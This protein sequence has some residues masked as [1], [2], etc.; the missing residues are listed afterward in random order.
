MKN[1]KKDIKN[2]IDFYKKAEKLKT[3]TRHSWTSNPSRQESVAEHSWMLCLL[4]ILL[5]DKLDGKVNLFKVLK[6]LIIHDLAEAVNGDIPAFEVSARQKL[7]HENEK[8][9]LKKLVRKL[10][11]QRAGEIVS[12]LKEFDDN[13]TPEAQFSNSL[14]KIEVLMQHNVS[15]ISTWGQGDFDTNPYYKDHFFNFSSFMR[16]LKNTIDNQTMKKIINTK[17]EHRVSKI[18]LE[19]YKKSKKF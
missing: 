10:P 16:T 1:N 5:F 18:H 3:T 12:L 11:K 15:D 7:K 4:A 19:K 13:K 14:D 17:K 6:M 2:L 9:A 8:K